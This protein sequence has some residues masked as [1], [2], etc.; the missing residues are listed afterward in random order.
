MLLPFSALCRIFAR[1]EESLFQLIL[2]GRSFG[3]Y[4]LLIPSLLQIVCAVVV[5]TIGVA[6]GD[7]FDIVAHQ[8]FGA[9]CKIIFRVVHQ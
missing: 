9:W 7:V 5:A 6:K 1:H 8:W 3:I 4:L 2:G